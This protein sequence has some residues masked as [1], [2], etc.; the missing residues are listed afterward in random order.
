MINIKELDIEQKEQAK[1]LAKYYKSLF[2]CKFCN[3]VCGSDKKQILKI[4]PICQS[5][6]KRRK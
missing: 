6:L 2:L 1:D 5:I 3:K 4:C